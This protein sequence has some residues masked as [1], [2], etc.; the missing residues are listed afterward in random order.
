MATLTIVKGFNQGARFPLKSERISLGRN[1]NSDIVIRGD[2]VSRNHARIHVQDGQFFI[3]DL[4]SRNATYLNDQKIA[5]ET[6][7]L[8]RDKDEIR[9]CDNVFLFHDRPEKPPLPRD[10]QKGGPDAE[11]EE[12]ST[13]TVEA[14]FTHGGSSKFFLETQPAEKLAFLLDIIAELTQ[15]FDFDIILPRIVE[16]LFQVFKQADRCFVIFLEEGTQR[17]I[18]RITRTRR[19]NDDSPRYSRSVVRQCIEIGQAVLSEDTTADVRFNLSQSIADYRIRSVMCAPLKS[20]TGDRVF[21]VLQLDTQDRSKRFCEEDLKLLLAVAGQASIALDNARLHQNM[22]SR[23]HLERDLV[24]AHQVQLSFLPK[25]PPQVPGY[26]FYAHY[27]S[28][29]EVGGDYY[30]FVPLPERRI[31]AMIGDVAGKGVPAALLMAKIS[32]DA[33]FAL[34]TEATP[35]D[36]VNKLNDFMQEA[37]KLD[38]FVTL[39]A[40]VV[41]PAQHQVTF[42][43][44]GHLPPLIYRHKHDHFENGFGNNFG[45]PP[46]GVM[47]LFPYDA[48]TVSLDA[49]DTVLLFSDGVTDSINKQGRDFPLE[50]ILDVLKHGPKNPRTMVERLIAAIKTHSLGCK[51]HDDITVVSFGRNI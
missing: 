43:S 38:R 8:L 23:A 19:N 28:A 13:S 11:D 14:T 22:L 45:G 46:L 1:E 15:S 17:L 29:Q 32:S 36:V 20:R 10:M 6:R 34:L 44:A 25:A 39:G 16:S 7:V 35:A 4:G 47:P 42:S 37:A 33:R 2:A 12:I 26:E 9:I 5:A 50:D 24:L 30:D 51:Q 41:D 18:P 31:A 40:A 3:E 49:G 27:E 21:G 48:C